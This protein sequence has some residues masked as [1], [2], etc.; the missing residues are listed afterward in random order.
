MP[1]E[2]ECPKCSVTLRATD[3]MLA[4]KP[5]WP[6]PECGVLI[7]VKVESSP[8]N[9]AVQPLRTQSPQYCEGSNRPR[10]VA[11]PASGAMPA[12]RKFPKIRELF[13]SDFATYETVV[14]LTN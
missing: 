1:F 12:N 5:E 8:T 13:W 3:A 14:F 6:C 10:R 9:I 2:L 4:S 11:G 7:R